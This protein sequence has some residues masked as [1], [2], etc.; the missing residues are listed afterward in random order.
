MRDRDGG[1]LYV[2]KA[3]Q[4]AP[5][6]ALLLRARRA[7]RAAHRAGARASW[8]R[9]TTRRAGR[10]SRRSCGR[11]DL[12]KDAAARRATGAARGAG[13]RYLKLSS[14]PR[15]PRLYA[16]PR[17][18]P[19]GA[20]LLR[21]G[22]LGSAWRGSAVACLR[23]LYP[24]GAP[25]RPAAR[26]RRRRRARRSAVGRAGGAGPARPCASRWP[27]HDG[28]LAVDR[29]PPDGPAAALLGALGGARPGP[30]GAGQLAVLRR[31]RRARRA[32]SRPSSS[33]AGWSA[34]RRR[35][36]AR[37]VARAARRGLA[38]VRA[39]VAAAAAAPRAA[40][41]STSSAIVE[42]R[43]RDAGR[44]AAPALE[45]P[46]GWSTAAALAG[47]GRAVARLGA[48][49]SRCRATPCGPPPP[50]RSAA[51]TRAFGRQAAAGLRAWAGARR[52]RACAIEDDRSDPAESARLLRGAR[53]RAPTSLFGPYGS[54]PARAV[55]EAM[56][57]RPEVVWNHGGG[58]RAPHRGARWSTCSGPARAL[59]ARAARGAR[60]RSAPTSAASS[61]S[62]RPGAS[63]RAVAGG[64]RGALARGRRAGAPRRSTSTRPTRRASRA[65]RSPPGRG[66]VV[67]GGRA[68]D[69]LALGRAARRHRARAGLVVCGVAL[70]GEVLGD[71]VSGWIGPAQWAPGGTVAPGPAAAGR[72]LP[73]R[74]G[75]R[76]RARRRAGRSRAAGSARAR[77]ALGRR[78]RAAHARPSSGPSRSTTRAAR[79]RTAPA[80][81]RWRR[82]GRP[83]G[84][85]SRGGHSAAA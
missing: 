66:W 14:R 11:T 60:G 55:A 80:I 62:R 24:L 61:C 15:A 77:R 63:A 72:R 69:D 39:R 25:G 56:A 48:G 49:P 51:A 83:C 67:G 50:S 73:R 20:R 35:A 76:R 34:T 17:A 41:P 59:L 9:S 84:G 46:P 19:D 71:A 3:D 6:R 7:P 26:A 70:A 5:P 65:R 38:I 32:A 79:R 74:P 68:E 4:P 21:A 10:S 58:G 54:G 16:V 27:S 45:L 64:A 47:I 29:A 53:P 13:G 85:R 33:P 52:R 81:V 75:A 23:L 82:P 44:R 78:P 12:I 28:R 42:D 31:A 30:P 1:V 22:P 2:G 18:L 36:D 8:S 40:T 37:A 43:L 57:G